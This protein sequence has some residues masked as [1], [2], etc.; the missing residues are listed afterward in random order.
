MD[1]STTGS[2]SAQNPIHVKVTVYN[3]NVSDLTKY[4]SMISFTGS[5]PVISG[6]NVNVISGVS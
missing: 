6:N 3:S 2:F 5:N 4:I 1:F